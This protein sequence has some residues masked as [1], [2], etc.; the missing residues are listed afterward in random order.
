MIYVDKISVTDQFGLDRLFIAFSITNTPESLDDY[1]FDLYRS[2]NPL[3]DFMPIATD[4]KTF[5]YED[6]GVNL[7]NRSL[8]Y[9]YKIQV[10]KISTND[11]VWSEAVGSYMRS[12]GDNYANAII[13]IENKYLDNVVGNETFALYKKRQSGQICSCYDNVRRRGQPDCP[14][15]YGTMI[16]GGYYPPVDMKIN[17]VNAA[18]RQHR[19]EPFG[20]FDDTSP[21]QLWTKNFPLIANEDVFVDQFGDAYIVTNWVPSYKNFYLLRQTVAV[22][23]IPR[24]SSFYNV[25]KTGGEL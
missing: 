19:M 15:C 7:F 12:S 1:R 24:K 10:T 25:L 2:L 6:Y 3:N 5:S 21:V 9:Y 4:I 23:R 8:H 16:V 13:T 17:F 22:T 14:L 20:D 18:Q 11:S